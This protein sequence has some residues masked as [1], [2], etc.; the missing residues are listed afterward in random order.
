MSEYQDIFSDKCPVCGGK[1]ADRNIY[2]SL[3]CE[4]EDNENKDN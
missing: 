1:M 2:C 4:R 3:K